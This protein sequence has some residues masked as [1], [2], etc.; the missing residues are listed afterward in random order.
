TIGVTALTLSIAF[1]AE[2]IGLIPD[3]SKEKLRA[4]SRIAEALTI[5]LSAAAARDDKLAIDQTIATVV[6]RDPAILSIAMRRK[7]GSIVTMTKNHG[8]FWNE[9]EG[10]L[11]TPA[12]VQ[13]PLY[14]GD[15]Y[16]GRVE[17][18]F[19]ELDRS[20]SL[21]GFSEQSLKL[22]AFFGVSGLF[23]Y[24]LLLWRSLRQLDPGKVVP[25][26]VQ[27][28]FDTL[29]EGVAIVDEK[30]QVLLINDS[31]ADLVGKTPENV[32]GVNLSEF[33][34]RHWE[35]DAA[36]IGFPWRTAISERKISVQ[37]PMGIRLSNN[38]I[39][40]FNVNASCIVDEDGSTNGAIVTFSDVTMLEKQNANLEMTVKKLMVTEEDLVQRNMELQYLASH[41][42]MTGC[43]NRRSLFLQFNQF[44]DNALAGGSQLS[45]LMIDID[46]FKNINDRYGHGVGDDVIVGVAKVLSSCCQYH[47]VVGRYGGEEFCVVLDNFGIEEASVLAEEI[48]LSITETSHTWLQQG[49]TA[50]VSIGLAS[51]DDGAESPDELVNKADRALYV[52][53][54]SGRNKLVCWRDIPDNSQDQL[55]A[56]ELARPAASARERNR[57]GHN[58]TITEDP[59]FKSETVR[60][61][62]CAPNI[63]TLTG[64]PSI[65]VFEDRLAHAISRAE[66]A[67]Q[68]V[69]VLSISIDSADQVAEAFGSQKAQKIVQRAG[70]KLSNL[71]RRTDTIS[72]L[73]GRDRIISFS[74]SESNKFVVE[75]SQLSEV[76]SVTWIIKRLLD[77]LGGPCEFDGTDHYL[78]CTIGVA[79]FPDD[80]KDSKTLIHHADIAQLRAR[81]EDG[82]NSFRFFSKDMG[83]SIKEQFRVESGIRDALEANDFVLH[84]QP[85][86]NLESGKVAAAEALLRCTKPELDGVPTD[87]LINVA[88]HTGLMQKLGD[89]I[90]RS[91]TAQMQNWIEA[92]IGLPMLSIN[93][94]AKQLVDPGNA[95]RLAD[96]ILESQCV[97]SRIQLEITETALLSDLK[98]AREVLSSV[99]KIGVQVALDDFGTG[100][101]SLTYL[102]RLSPDAIKID[103]SFIDGIDVSH[104]NEALVAAVT[105]LSNRLGLRVV[106]EGVESEDQLGVLYN[107]G[108]TE[109]QGYLISPPMPAN[110]FTDWLRLFDE[111]RSSP[112]QM[113]NERD[114]PAESVFL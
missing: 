39:K 80:G 69:A 32:I 74:R 71:L 110:V 23:L 30:E 107:L 59:T 13:V 25:D 106:A 26:R 87:M 1:G 97:P 67:D 104:A 70:E 64:L 63:D 60:Q 55:L 72:L 19:S 50:T 100:Q 45:C 102:Q 85:I 52:A 38:E 36:N 9:P 43:N 33:P 57:D 95:G 12:S 82:S 8:E 93:I 40:S 44:M 66:R 86:I 24:Y 14:N 6:T 90:V 58:A 94:S 91:A 17:I 88:E 34:W 3:V 113:P 41:D 10:N 96:L 4:R 16:W 46:H 29:D 65:S 35:D 42:P 98:L 37:V 49:A 105:E 27:A 108:C 31:L 5:Q 68:S 101:S 54:E 21:I 7:D 62:N 47:G 56:A 112:Q 81:R 28:A 73:S 48:R 79:M 75:I 92:G 51:L 2:F 11:S 78:K 20:Y 103:R 83:E 109:I 53:K 77:N 61:K 114:Q 76:G 84:F 22:F 89:W 99:Q 15:E 111:N 18:A